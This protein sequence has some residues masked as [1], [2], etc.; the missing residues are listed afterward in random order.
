MAGEVYC[1][2]QPG[3]ADAPA[4]EVD[5]EN[6]VLRPDRVVM[7]R[8]NPVVAS[9]PLQPFMDSDLRSIP[10]PIGVYPLPKTAQLRPS[11]RLNLCLTNQ[12]GKAVLAAENALSQLIGRSERAAIHTAHRYLSY[13]QEYQR[14]FGRLPKGDINEASFAF[15]D[16]YA[17]AEAAL[18]YAIAVAVPKTPS[19]SGAAK[20]VE[21]WAVSMMLDKTTAYRD[22]GRER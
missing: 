8:T 10:I 20:M 7:P 15:R 2:M 16:A 13:D 12:T 5:T 9:K 4:T 1:F 19:S 17:K 3:L 11:T 6:A 14:R 21:E 18:I 22:Y